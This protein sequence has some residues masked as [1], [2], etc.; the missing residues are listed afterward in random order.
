MHSCRFNWVSIALGTTVLSAVGCG[1]SNKAFQAPS[2]AGG[3]GGSAQSSAVEPG[4]GGAS[5]IVSSTGSPGGASSVIGG[6][7]GTST[8]ASS[9]GGTGGASSPSTGGQTTAV[10]DCSSVAKGDV[11][12]SQSSRVFKGALS[13]EL[14]TSIANAEIRYTLDG[15]APTASSTVY[16]NAAISITKTTRLRAQGFVGGAAAGVAT[17]ALY[18]ASAIDGTH[19]IPVLVLDSYGSGKLPTEAAQRKFVDVG[20]LG[21]APSGGTASLAGTP[22]I[23]SMAAFHVRG[24]SSAMFDKVPYRLELRNEAGGDRDCEMFGMPSEA[25]W[26]LIGPHADKTLVHNAFVYDLSREMGLQVSRLKFVEVYLNVDN[27]PLAADDYQGVYQ[28]V[29][30]IKNQKSRLNLKQLDESKTTAEQIT[31]GYI[32]KFE[33]M[34]AEEPLLPCPSGT[35]NGWKD[36]EL[37]DPDPIAAVQKDYL[38][39]HLVSFN[40][41]LH[42]ADPA[43]A[44]TGA[45][46]FID[47]K[48]FVDQVIINEFTRNMD[49][50]VRSQYFY[51]DRGGKV[52]A[53]PVWDFDL[54]AGVGLKPGG[55][56]G[57]MSNTA[58]SGWQY[59]GN[60]SRLAGATADWFP[61]LIANPKFKAQLI[62]RWKELRQTLLADAAVSARIDAVSNGLANAADRNFKRWPILSQARVEPFDTPT[63]ATWSA[64]LTSMKTWLKERSLWLDGQWK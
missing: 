10:V 16:A 7:A 62:A 59:E 4:L 14:A 54:I 61:V 58:T 15:K 1:D 12:V 44:T 55:F 27:Q 13:V 39:K 47:L 23:A 57:A 42:G 49:A 35:V 64:Q 24:N 36:L 33:W 41:A 2:S 18:V 20:V 50:F 30:T 21:F 46:A 19:D 5:S 29:E 63:D 45:P 17:T 38:T 37:V 52:F 53:G 40:T 25:D 9:A 11:T 32:F 6:S 3:S 22:T 28:L 8:I 43:N 56:G 31:G 51:K 48:S 34:A 26:A 60:A